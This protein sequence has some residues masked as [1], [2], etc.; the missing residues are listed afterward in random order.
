[1]SEFESEMQRRV[2][3][4]RLVAEEGVTVAD[5]ARTVGRSRQWL[6]KWVQRARSGEGLEDRSRA[7][8][9]SFEPL[10]NDIVAL[11]LLHRE[12]L[13]EDDSM[14]SVGGVA[15]L[16]A[17]ERA[18]I[19][20][21]PSVRS[22]ERIL[23]RYGIARPKTK[24]QSRSTTPILP[25]PQVGPMPGVW[26]QTDWVQNRYLKGGVKYNSI[27][28][29]DM[30]SKGGIAY[31]YQHRTMINVVEYLVERVWPV[32]SIP[33]AIS[34]DNAFS[35]TTHPNNPWTLFVR[36]CL[37]F[38]V[39]PVISPPHELGFT[40]GVENF[41]N[42]WQDRTIAKRRYP[43]LKALAADTDRFNDWANHHRPI[44]DPNT[45]AT[46]Y[47]AVLIE[48]C[49]DTL[50]WP[51]DV[52]IADHLDTKGKLHIPLTNG[53]ITFLRR[54]N[55]KHI[56]IG[57]RDWHIDLPDHTLIIATITTSNAALTLR[58]QGETHITHLYPITQPI[59]APQ[60]LP[61][62]HSIYHHA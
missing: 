49:R 16:A 62:P 27:Q 35:S 52:L 25:L 6:S 20:E 23:T 28:L 45:A 21:L 4:V 15:I 38:G 51:P 12:Q 39:E 10:N 60:H 44:L 37:F 26:Q 61:Q 34:V 43:N 5:A 22:I 30:G 32:L 24:K 48:Q 54:V 36:V 2:E 59:T 13:D 58:H 19:A 1:M 17:M 47:P 56:R 57:H 41:N 18:G 55:N 3:A 53:R 42:L 11:V 9:T 14:E 33:H 29:L 31:Q 46:R 7:S 50:Q 40:N 8:S